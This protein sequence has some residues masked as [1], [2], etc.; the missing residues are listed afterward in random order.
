[1]SKLNVTKACLT[2]LPIFFLFGILS[3]AQDELK[4]KVKKI[5]GDVDK[6]TITAGGEE[7]SFEGDE[8]KT[9]F[10]KM[11]SG[12]SKSHSFMWH[13]DDGE[14]EHHDGKIIMIDEDGNKKV[15]EISEEGD[16]DIDI[17]ISKDFDMDKHDGMEKKVKVEIEDGKKKVTITTKENGEEK[18]EIYEGEEAEEYLDKMKSEHGKEMLIEIDEN[19]K[20]KKVRKI[21]I[22]KE[23]GEDEDDD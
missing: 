7:Y 23:N 1:M 15:I 4:D 6:I 9:L 12:L 11:K 14:F 18:T 13:S 10:K 3:Y 17:F 2:F 8:A 16:E 20:H 19:D 22:E 21:I 5:E